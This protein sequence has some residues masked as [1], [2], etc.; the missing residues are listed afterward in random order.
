MPQE[1]RRLSGWTVAAVSTSSSGRRHIPLCGKREGCTRDI[2]HS[3]DHM[4]RNFESAVFLDRDGTI[5]RLAG[6]MTRS[7]LLEIIPGAAESLVRLAHAGFRCILVT[8]QSAIGRGL[9]TVHMLREIHA[10]LQRLLEAGG[11]RLDAIYDCPVAP[12]TDAETIVDHPD[13]KPGPG[14]LLKAATDLRIDLSRSWM[15]GDRLSGVLAGVNAGCRSIRVQTGYQYQDPVPNISCDYVTL[16][17][18]RE[19]AEYILTESES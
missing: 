12:G 17:S 14:M 10:K 18:V 2:G 15:V 11:A 13:R 6:Y 9:M 16:D 19:A 5:T 7:G 3:D 1:G 8:N 4:N